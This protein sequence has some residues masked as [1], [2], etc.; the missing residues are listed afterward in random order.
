MYHNSPKGMYMRHWFMFGLWSLSMQVQLWIYI[1][2][3]HECIY[4]VN[5]YTQYRHALACWVFLKRV[6]F[7]RC[8]LAIARQICIEYL[9]KHSE[10]VCIGKRGVHVCVT[11]CPYLHEIY[12]TE[13][14]RQ[15]KFTLK[16]NIIKVQ[17]FGFSS[18][19]ATQFFCLHNRRVK[20]DIIPIVHG[21]A[22]YKKRMVWVYC[23][24]F[25]QIS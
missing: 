25:R 11:F 2:C 4:I 9:A 5:K 23:S 7:A 22:A 17:H 20:P 24:T 13:T 14:C 10:L 19:H 18:K 1:S 12:K 3:S 21:V 6:C 8:Q 16:S 15:N